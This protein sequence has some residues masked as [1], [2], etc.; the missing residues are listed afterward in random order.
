MN[1]WHIHIIACEYHQLSHKQKLL[2]LK[3]V[4]FLGKHALNCVKAIKLL[5][6]ATSSVSKCL[7]N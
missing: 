7:L 5:A 2:T 3:Y 6:C 4:L 1:Y